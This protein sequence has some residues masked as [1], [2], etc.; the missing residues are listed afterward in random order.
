MTE[1]VDDPDGHGDEVKDADDVVD[2]RVVGALLVAVVERVELRGHHPGRQGDQEEQPLRARG[3]TLEEGRPGGEE[4]LGEEERRDQADHVGDEERPP[5][6]PAATVNHSGGGVVTGRANGRSLDVGRLDG[7]PLVSVS[8][9]LCLHSP[10]LPFPSNVRP[11]PRRR[12]DHLPLTR[13]PV[14]ATLNRPHSGGPTGRRA[15]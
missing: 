11:D 13:Y 7:D 2:G 6:E 3:E 15:S 4:R 10:G 5:D 9:R 8:G 14:R 12:Q 1:A